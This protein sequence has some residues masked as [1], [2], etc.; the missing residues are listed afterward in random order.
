MTIESTPPSAESAPTFKIDELELVFTLARLITP[1]PEKV[2]ADRV[3]A[4]REASAKVV[5]PAVIIPLLE[6]VTEPVM[7]PFPVSVADPS[8]VM[9]ELASELFTR[10][11][12][13]LIAVEPV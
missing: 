11:V 1:V 4:P 13:A 8:T 12:P 10:S 2:S 9:L 3:R 6:T 5:S 7:V